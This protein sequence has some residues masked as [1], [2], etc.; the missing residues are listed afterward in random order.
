MFG[1]IG[2]MG[3]GGEI[4]RAYTHGFAQGLVSEFTGGSFMTGFAAGGLGSLAGSSFMMY[5]GKFAS[6]TL[7]TSA[8]SALAGG[9]GAELTG[10]DFWR[11][12]ATGLM[13]AGLNH[14][15]NRAQSQLDLLAEKI[16]NAAYLERS[17]NLSNIE[18]VTTPFGEFNETIN[19][20][21]TVS[22]AKGF[23]NG[24][25]LKIGD[26]SVL[27]DV[28][29]R[30]S[31]NNIVKYFNWSKNQ[32]TIAI[33]PAGPRLS[34]YIMYLRNSTRYDVVTLRF[35]TESNFNAFRNYLSGK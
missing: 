4:A 1:P 12:A 29:Y 6:S 17:R 15:Q 35:R 11:G 2:S 5:G 18:S 9:A 28:I 14:L 7:G 25:E 32:P 20:D 22:G 26:K 16:T 23:H 3:F 8:F 10:G 13:M 34:G 33:V 27:A 19:Y 30:P 24:L 31:R 21:I